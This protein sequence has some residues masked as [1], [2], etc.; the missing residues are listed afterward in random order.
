MK[1]LSKIRIVPLVL[2]FIIMACASGIAVVN[3]H[4]PTLQ[5]FNAS[6]DHVSV[7]VDGRRIGTV[8][9]DS[10][11]FY[12][13]FLQARANVISFKSI[14]QG[15]YAAPAIDLDDYEGWQVRLYRNWHFDVQSLQPAER[16]EK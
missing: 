4:T 10:D 15:T 6:G 14:A 16:C 1:Q 11:C 8:T 5:V 9:G 2:V 7:Y 13:R 3:A 12:L